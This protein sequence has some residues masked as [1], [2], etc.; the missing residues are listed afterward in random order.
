MTQDLIALSR[1]LLCECLPLAVI[2][3]F[4]YRNHQLVI[5]MW[6]RRCYSIANN[7]QP[8]D[9]TH[10]EVMIVNPPLVKDQSLMAAS[11]KQESVVQQQQE[12]GIDEGVTPFSKHE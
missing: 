10:T 7:Q 9:D 8:P 4:Q 12:Y 2:M 11:V 1:Y 5:K 6:S 3:L